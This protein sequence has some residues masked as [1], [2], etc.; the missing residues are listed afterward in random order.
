MLKVKT[1]L[2]ESPIESAGIGLFAAEF[3]PKGT[4]VWRIDTFIDKL[5]TEEEYQ[6]VSNPLYKEFL[7]KYCFMYK[8]LYVMC[9][10]N[11]R[12]FN[13]SDDPNC[14]SVNLNDDEMGVTVAKVDI[15][16]GDELTDDYN[17]FGSIDSDYEFNKMIL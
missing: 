9:V 15:N 1:Y 16:I 4:I 6:S 8:G 12:F 17:K 10:D 5:Y 2:S 3:I 7:I 14:E 13:H 11:A